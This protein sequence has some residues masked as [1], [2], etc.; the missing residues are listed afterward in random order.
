MPVIEVIKALRRDFMDRGFLEGEVY[1]CNGAIYPIH[2]EGRSFSLTMPPLV[3]G[4]NPRYYGFHIFEHDQIT[5]HDDSGDALSPHLTDAE[6]SDLGGQLITHLLN[7]EDEIRNAF[8]EEEITISDPAIWFFLRSK[9]LAPNKDKIL[10]I[11]TQLL[12]DDFEISDSPDGSFADFLDSK[13]EGMGGEEFAEMNNAGMEPIR[14]FR[15]IRNIALLEKHDLFSI[16]HLGFD[17]DD[18]QSE[19]T[20]L[21]EARFKYLKRHKKNILRETPNITEA[22]LDS[23]LRETYLQIKEKSQAEVYALY[24]GFSPE[25]ALEINKRELVALLSLAD[26]MKK[27]FPAL[28]TADLTKLKSDTADFT[29]DNQFHGILIG[30][31]KDRAA[32]LTGEDS[33][34]NPVLNH[35]INLQAER[36]SAGNRELSTEALGAIFDEIQ[37]L[38]A[39]QISAKAL[40][41]DG[42]YLDSMTDEDNWIVDF[43]TDR[44]IDIRL[45]KP[46]LA[47]GEFKTLLINLCNDASLIDKDCLKKQISYL[48][49]LTEK[50]PAINILAKFEEI[51]H[52]TNNLQTRAMDL[53]LDI[54]NFSDFEV[55]ENNAKRIAYLERK[56]ER[57]EES[58]SN[59]LFVRIKDFDQHQLT[60]LYDASFPPEIAEIFNEENIVHLPEIEK[61]GF[62]KS[63]SANDVRENLLELQKSSKSSSGEKRRREDSPSHASGGVASSPSSELSTAEARLSGI[64]TPSSE[65]EEGEIVEGASP[66]HDGFKKRR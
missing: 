56:K 16:L 17:Y 1:E 44:K 38:N 39:C 21:G 51:K 59:S 28:S 65:I 46:D 53:D 33:T 40:G 32:K 12:R 25:D 57:N 49:R 23:R 14:F 22:D 19:E 11:I 50:D 18:T 48:E 60:A 63:L 41:F 4:G 8:D 55:N 2:E 52:C 64:G 61:L 37:N 45:S 35:L 34:E 5:P 62:T 15:L 30:L 20:T 54:E 42:A 10:P 26:E 3:A 43:I 47:P 9:N 13:P 27:K 6:A 7:T 66:S 24:L 31:D 58:D 36:A 29:H